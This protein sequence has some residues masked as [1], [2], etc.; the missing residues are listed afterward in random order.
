MQGC[1]NE[2][3]DAGMAGRKVRIGEPFSIQNGRVAEGL[4]NV[5]EVRQVVG[6]HETL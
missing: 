1:E 5:G 6:G 3:L 4:G 2:I